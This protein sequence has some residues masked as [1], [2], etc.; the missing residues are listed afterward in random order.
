MGTVVLR[1]GVVSG[2]DCEA[3]CDI[4]ARRRSPDLGSDYVEGFIMGAPAYLPDGDY[5]VVFDSHTMAA[6]KRLGLWLS[7]APNRT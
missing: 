2:S 1:R 6:T 7:S 3:N 4:L 5:L